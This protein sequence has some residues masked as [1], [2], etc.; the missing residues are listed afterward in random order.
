MRSAT[1]IACANIA[2]V[3]YWGKRDRAL[4]LPARGSLS[5]TL[6]ALA[7]TTT[8][9][10]LEPLEHGRADGASDEL[11]L[12]GVPQSGRALAR[13]TKHLDLVRA[14][15]GSRTRVRVTSV[16]GF[17]TAAGLASSASGFA[18]LSVAAAHAFEARLD[19]RE[20]S[21][22]ARRGS[23]S[24]AR[25]IFG[26]YVRMYAGSA[27]DGSDA[28]AAPLREAR[29]DLGAV[30]AVARA[31]EKEVGSTDGMEHTRSTSPYHGAWFDQVDLDLA[32]A[33]AALAAGDFEALAAVTEG[34]C[35]GMHADAMAARPGILYFGPVTLWAIARVRQLRRAGT[36]VFFTVDAGP[37]LVAFAPR[38]ALPS[39]AAALG[40][41]PEIAEVLVSGPGSDARVVGEGEGG[42]RSP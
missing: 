18:A 5:L 40:E 33:E 15:T 34:S 26:G 19:G 9:E 8:I 2:L 13:V 29:L 20:L 27:S 23:G 17:P 38:A 21:V 12:D 32:A 39:V 14:R 24:A 22:L 10:P 1:A 3:K 7:T 28:F 41:H 30:I 37:H 35:L 16:N 25:S 11:V 42:A 6:D 31:S 36:P 4:N